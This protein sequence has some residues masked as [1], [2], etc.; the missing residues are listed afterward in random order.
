MV[1]AGRNHRERINVEENVETDLTIPYSF[2]SFSAYAW[3]FNTP[4]GGTSC[5]KTDHVGGQA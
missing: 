3:I 2:I 4:P 5:V 1:M